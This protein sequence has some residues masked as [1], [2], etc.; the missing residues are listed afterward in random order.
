MK[1]L[2]ANIYAVSQTA[3]YPVRS[4]NIRVSGWELPGYFI[5]WQTLGGWQ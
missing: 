2:D 4:V 1:C 3:S 5:R